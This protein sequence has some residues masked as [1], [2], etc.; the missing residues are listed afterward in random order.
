MVRP[1]GKQPMDIV[2]NIMKVIEELNHLKDVDTILDRVLFQAR[3]LTNAE[4]G[5][6]FL[7][8]EGRLQFSYVHN[9]VLFRAQSGNKHIYTDFSLPIDDKSIVGYAA[10]TGETL[11]IDDA[12]TLAPD[13]P[14]SFNSSF[15]QESGYET[16]SILT[17]PLK[18]LRG[19]RV[20]VIQLINARDAQ[21]Q[22]RPFTKQDA[23]YAPFFANHAS[24]AIERG[25]M[26]RELILRMMK[27]AEM[28]DP[29]E[30]GAHVMRVGSYSAE[31]YSKISVDQ[32]RDEDEVRRTK[33]LIRLAAMLH[34]VGKVGIPDAILKKPGPLNPEE[35][36]TMQWHTVY[37]A[38]LFTNATSDLDALC[39][40]IALHHHER[41]DGGGYP[42]SL[43]D[44]LNKVN[45]VCRQSLAGESIPL[46]AR[47]CALADV[48]DAL[49][50][51]RSY[52]DAWPEDDI[53]ELIR[54][55]RGK[56]F[57]PLVVDAF[58]SIY[59]TIQAIKRKYQETD[60]QPR[61]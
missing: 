16:H 42:G 25:I 61:H 48:Y 30:T 38:A 1:A 53:L 6:I 49:G 8:H 4:A 20:G 46:P 29:A 55:E 43:P 7:V 3:Q 11:I 40:D 9:D 22:V 37:G 10:L 41:W 13:L 15:D 57:D 56:H 45:G 51:V 5:S 50:S 52:K 21:G 14:Y 28:R 17:I 19:N 33:D 60:S 23:E 2:K 35:F 27:M 36:S 44:D 24:V 47:I 54:K 39:R 59:D 12:Y 58:F 31:L 18:T 26:T 32:G 34:D